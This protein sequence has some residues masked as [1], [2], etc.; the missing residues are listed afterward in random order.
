MSKLN[1][2]REQVAKMQEKAGKKSKLLA[3]KQGEADRALTAITSSM[4]VWI[5]FENVFQINLK[6]FQSASDQHAEI[7]VLKEDA[8]K[9]NARIEKQKKV[10][11][12]QLKEV[13]PLIPAAQAA[14]GSIKNDDLTIIRSLR[15][16]P[17]VIR[18]I[19][20][21]VLLFMGIYDSSWQS[22]RRWDLLNF[23]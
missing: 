15:A 17:E 11:E 21:S 4:T 23:Y 13:E 22:M 14:V 1:E 9:E 5:F 2:A 12:E 18:D 8:E 7:S 20:E 6:N 19:L 16:P 3:E 10:I